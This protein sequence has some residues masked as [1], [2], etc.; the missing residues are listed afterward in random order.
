[1][2]S[3]RPY[4]RE[5]CGLGVLKNTSYSAKEMRMAEV[6]QIEKLRSDH[7]GLENA[8]E[9]ELSRPCPDDQLLADMKRQKLRIKDEL[10]RLEAA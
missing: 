1:V 6:E 8:I 9:E 5:A 4:G 3:W 10:Q 7:T 2:K